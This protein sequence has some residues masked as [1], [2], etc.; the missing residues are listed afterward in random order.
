MHFLWLLWDILTALNI[1]F[2]YIWNTFRRHFD[3]ICHTEHKCQGS[4]L[5]KFGC[6]KEVVHPK[7][8]S[9]R[10]ENKCFSLLPWWPTNICLWK[11][12]VIVDW[13]FCYCW[14]RRGIWGRRWGQRSGYHGQVMQMMFKVGGGGWRIQLMNGEN[15]ATIASQLTFVTGSASYFTLLSLSTMRV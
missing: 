14:G 6:D 12:C 15:K 13:R 1:N 5:W 2:K 10:V 9:W 8:V 3:P 4:N 11:C 7:C